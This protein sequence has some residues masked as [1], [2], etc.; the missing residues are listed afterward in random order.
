MT[1]KN[2][3]RTDQV[4][5][6]TMHREDK[7]TLYQAKHKVTKRIRN[8]PLKRSQQLTLFTE[9]AVTEFGG[10]LLKGHRKTKRPLATNKPIHLVLKTTSSF[11]LLRNRKTV[12]ATITR[13]AKRFGVT[14]YQV[15]VH[16]DH[17]HLAI[18]IPQR[19]AYTG[20][21]RSLTGVMARRI[22]GLKFRFRPYTRIASWGKPFQ[23]MKTYIQGNQREAD[24]IVQAHDHVEAFVQ[25]AL[26]PWNVHSLNPSRAKDFGT[27][28]F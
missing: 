7:G 18:R 24:F 9:K 8:Q 10:S 4:M 14:I 11:I 21:I 26:A 20:W 19:E 27:V 28:R 6:T 12:Q 25:R 2:L 13:L 15:A 1:A 22:P 17:V 3:I 5:N 23:I 16:A